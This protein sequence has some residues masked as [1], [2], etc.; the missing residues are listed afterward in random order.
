HRD[1]AQ[2]LPEVRLRSD[3]RGRI[4]L[5]TLEDV[6]SLTVRLGNITQHWPIRT[7]RADHRRTLTATQGSLIHVPWMRPTEAPT[8]GEL[9]LLE[10]RGSTYAIDRFEHLHIADGYLVLRDLPAGDYQL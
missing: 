8:R 7:P 4:D 10:M 1:L 5:G 3:E 2:P 6:E 9:S